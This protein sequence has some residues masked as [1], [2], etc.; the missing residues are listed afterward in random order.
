MVA[1]SQ[2]IDFNGTVRQMLAAVLLGIAAMGQETRRER[3][4]VGIAAA[5]KR[6]VYLG[7]RAGTMNAKSERAAELRAKGNMVE[8]IGRALGVSRNTVF[9]YLRK[10][11][12]RARAASTGRNS[13]STPGPGSCSTRRRPARTNRS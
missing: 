5:R 7:R 4:A 3:S 13:G 11:G 2:Q 10:A 1:T 6:G 8:E 9:V 12:A